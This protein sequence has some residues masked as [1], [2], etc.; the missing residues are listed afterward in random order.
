MIQLRPIALTYLIVERARARV[1]LVIEPKLDG[2]MR[3]WLEK[4]GQQIHASICERQP[5]SFLLK[6]AGAAIHA[7]FFSGLTQSFFCTTIMQRLL[8]DFLFVVA[9]EYL[10]R[11]ITDPDRYGLY[12]TLCP[13]IIQEEL[14]SGIGKAVI[15]A[16]DHY[17][18]LMWPRIIG[19]LVANTGGMHDALTAAFLGGTTVLEQFVAQ[20]VSG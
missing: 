12:A 3:V 13:R 19:P 18:V 14:E 1:T 15:S 5:S 10:G 6:Q 11:F 2:T 17:E 16:L 7:G 4:E 9:P 20:Q 8:C